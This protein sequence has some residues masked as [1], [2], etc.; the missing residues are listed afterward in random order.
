MAGWG[1][2]AYWNVQRAINILTRGGW[3]PIR[4]DCVGAE[5]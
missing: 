1:G 4:Y 3:W 2:G 5:G